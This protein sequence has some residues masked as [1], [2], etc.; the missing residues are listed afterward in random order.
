MTVRRFGNGV[1]Q[2]LER[3]QN[4]VPVNASQHDHSGSM[5]GYIWNANCVVLG[6]RVWKWLWWREGFVEGRFSGGVRWNAGC[7]LW[8]DKWKQPAGSRTTWSR[9]LG[10]AWRWIH[11]KSIEIQLHTWFFLRNNKPKAHIWLAYDWI[12]HEFPTSVH[13]NWR[14]EDQRHGGGDAECEEPRSDIQLVQPWRSLSNY[15]RPG[16][17]SRVMCSGNL[18]M[19]Q[20]FKALVPL[21]NPKIAGKWMFIPLKMYL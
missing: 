19:G 18:G 5:L 2:D 15:P 4:E 16:H 21:L 11:G 13:S 9:S 14:I 3:C 17:W 1:G 8:N 20:N 10:A 12:F 6:G 7:M